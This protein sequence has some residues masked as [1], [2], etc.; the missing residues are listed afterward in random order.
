[1][2]AWFSFWFPFYAQPKR[3]PSL[4]E[5]SF[6]LGSSMNGFGFPPGFPLPTKEQYPPK[7]NKQTGRRKRTE[8][9][10][11]KKDNT[12]KIRPEDAVGLFSAKQLNSRVQGGIELL[13]K[14][15]MLAPRR[16]IKRASSRSSEFRHERR[17]C[18]PFVRGFLRVRVFV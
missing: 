12:P 16:V 4:Q 2:L 17:Q 5:R 14:L 9:Q 3:R 11:E 6:I 15:L 7:K 8:Q 13:A 18:T 10:A 1:M